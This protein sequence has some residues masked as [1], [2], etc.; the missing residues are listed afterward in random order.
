[1]FKKL[2]PFS[3]QLQIFQLDEYSVNKFLQW[4]FSHFL[5]REIENKKALVWT[6]KAKT[7][8]YLAML[9]AILFIIVLT[10]YLKLVGFIL[11]ILFAT[12]SYLFLIV[13]Y[14]LLLPI[15]QYKKNKIKEETKN[16]IASLPKLKV[17]GVTGSYGKTSVKEFLYHILKTHY[18]VLKT[19]ESYNTPYGIAQVVDLELDDTYEYFV[20]EMGAYRVGEI[21][22]ICDMVHPNYGILTGINEQHLETFGSLEN[23][24]KGKFELIDSLPDKGFGVFNI[25]NPHIKNNYQKY[26]KKLIPYGFTDKENTIKNIRHHADGS[27][28]TLV[29]D[30]R[31]HNAKTKLLGKPN[32]QNILAAATMSYQLGV[33][34]N[35]II[36]AIA[37]LNPVPH[38]LEIKKL[39]HLT[40]IDDAYNSNVNGFKESISLLKD[41][42]QPKILVTPG[43]VDLGDQTISIHTKLGEL[44]DETDYIILVGK[45]E[46][47]HGLK[48][49]IKDKNKIIEVETLKSA[50]NK[51]QDLKLTHPVVLLE[52]DL[53]D[54][55]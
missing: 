45:S 51:I 40:I 34:P 28:F 47:T 54:N 44:L 52:N 49:G 2:F 18:S 1:M 10:I 27:E 55:Y 25:D 24:T 33:K 53:P 11:G 29:L 48:I 46:R 14:Y 9:V 37:N 42:K 32:L 22:E 43:I 31:E 15:E 7:I 35:A 50:W 21:K 6:Q 17:I 26:Q 20:C 23:T 36:S 5:S 3:L 16:K 8:Y 13:S 38:R 12:Q 39:E 19:P 30:G 4:I 41:F